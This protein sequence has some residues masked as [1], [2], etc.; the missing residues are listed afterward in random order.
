MSE[1]PRHEEV[2]LEAS[3]NLSWAV[4][5]INLRTTNEQ[6]QAQMMDALKRL[7][8]VIENK[9]A[10]LTGQIIEP[11]QRR[12]PTHESMYN[13]PL[14][15]VIRRYSTWQSKQMGN[16]ES[17]SIVFEDTCVLFNP[18]SKWVVHLARHIC[19][20]GCE[21]VDVYFCKL[22]AATCF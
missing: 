8:D 11:P 20:F 16:A 5:S 2:L 1:V 19:H 13:R 3:T 14:T 18:H 9:T 4:Q 12:V 21:R 7:Q 6:E 22:D 17:N 15:P 10:M